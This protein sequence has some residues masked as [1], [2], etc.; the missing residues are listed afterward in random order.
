[1]IANPSRKV[2]ALTSKEWKALQID[3]NLRMI[4]AASSD[5]APLELEIWKYDPKLLS[6]SGLVDPLS[7]YLSLADTND[8]RIEGALRDLLEDLRW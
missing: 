5:L 1:M 8:E 6:E 4:P 3:A 2:R 7:L